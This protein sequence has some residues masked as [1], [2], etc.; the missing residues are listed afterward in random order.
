MHVK[1]VRGSMFK[2]AVY[3]V[4]PNLPEINCCSRDTSSIIWRTAECFDSLPKV[5]EY[6]MSLK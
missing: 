6:A 1:T 5:K 3:I 4:V 2:G